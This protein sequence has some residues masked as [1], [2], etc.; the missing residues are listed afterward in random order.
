MLGLV[1]VCVSNIFSALLKAGHASMEYLNGMVATRQGK[2]ISR[3]RNLIIC[4]TGKIDILKII[5]E[6]WDL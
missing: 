4:L 3:S 5:K 2:K 1:C 6:N